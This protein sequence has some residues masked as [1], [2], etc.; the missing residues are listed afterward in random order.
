[1]TQEAQELEERTA[2]LRDLFSLHRERIFNNRDDRRNRL[3]FVFTAVTLIQSVLLWY[4]FLTS[5]ATTFGGAPRPAIALAVL[6]ATLATVIGAIMMRPRSAKR[7]S[8]RIAHQRTESATAK[9]PAPSLRVEEP[10]N[11]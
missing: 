8:A 1:V 4:D 10:A 6:V 2:A 5:D 7:R 11:R 9:T 3:I